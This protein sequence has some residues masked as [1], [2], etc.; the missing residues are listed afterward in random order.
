MSLQMNGVLHN[1][2]LATDA[3]KG[4]QTRQK[5]HWRHATKHSCRKQA[6]S[7]LCAVCSPNLPDTGDLIR[8]HGRKTVAHFCVFCKGGVHGP[9]PV[10][11]STP[12]TGGRQVFACH[13]FRCSSVLECVDGRPSRC[14]AGWCWSRSNGFGAATP[15]MRTAKRGSEHN[16]WGGATMRQR[17]RVACV[18]LSPPL[19][20][21]QR[22]ATRP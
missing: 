19:Q 8:Q 4:G 11:I 9:G 1:R 12:S 13:I 20:K 21:T 22:W 17:R 7:Q 6:F 5:A 10:G 15:A 3:I 16:Q 2:S 18:H 14:G